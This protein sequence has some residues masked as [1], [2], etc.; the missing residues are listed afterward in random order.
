MVILLLDSW[1]GISLN[2]LTS[3]RRSG[4]EPD[5]GK[6]SVEGLPHPLSIAL[7]A[8]Q[9]NAAAD[10]LAGCRVHGKIQLHVL[11]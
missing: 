10:G 9:Q 8:G 6:H 1:E 3:P 2:S 5:L 4:S 11:A 7:V